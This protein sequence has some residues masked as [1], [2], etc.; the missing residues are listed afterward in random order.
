LQAGGYLIKR[1]NVVTP[2]PGGAATTKTTVNTGMHIGSTDAEVL[3]HHGELTPPAIRRQMSPLFTRVETA[4][5]GRQAV[6]SQQQ[7][8]DDPIAQLERLARLR[9]SGIL[10]DEEFQAARAPLVRKLTE[11]TSS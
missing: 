8:T 10:S 7:T 1:D 3:L 11:G 9:E 5:R 4:R 2:T 6:P